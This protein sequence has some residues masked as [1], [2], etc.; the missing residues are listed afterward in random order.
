MK[1]TL[2]RDA[3]GDLHARRR[4]LQGL[5]GASIEVIAPGDS[6]VRPWGDLVEVTAEFITVAPEDEDEYTLPL[7]AIEEVRYL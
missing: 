7:A 5:V 2:S 3:A 6:Q 4:V 1:I